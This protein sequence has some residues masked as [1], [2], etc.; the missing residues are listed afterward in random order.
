MQHTKATL[1]SWKDTQLI[2][3]QDLLA[4]QNYLTQYACK[5]AAKTTDFIKIYELLTEQHDDST[6]VKRLCQRLLLKDI[7]KLRFT[8]ETTFDQFMSEKRRQ[9]FPNISLYDWAKICDPKCKCNCD[10]VPVFTGVLV[11]PKAA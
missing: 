9:K 11:K 5:G 6:S 1:L 7:I 8:K 10:H 3:K 4:L 2:L